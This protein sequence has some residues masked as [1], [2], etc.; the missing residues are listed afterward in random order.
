MEQSGQKLF[1]AERPSPGKGERG[2]EPEPPKDGKTLRGGEEFEIRA[3]SEQGVKAPTGRKP[4]RG[5]GWTEKAGLDAG[6]EK[7]RL[8][9]RFEGCFP[10]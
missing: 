6:K 8:R 4:L 5:G 1:S 10:S 7:A 3:L 2:P 9:K